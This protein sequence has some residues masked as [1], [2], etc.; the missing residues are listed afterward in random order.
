[1]TP[2]KRILHL[3]RKQLAWLGGSLLLA[4]AL[5]AGSHF[6]RLEMGQRVVL[7]QGRLAAQQAR[8]EETRRDLQ[9]IQS[10]IQEYRALK[11]KGLV[12]QPDREGWVEALTSSRSALKA[13]E[14]LS[15]VLGSP[16]PRDAGSPNQGEFAG[17][18]ERFHDLEFEL[19]N[20]HEEELLGL[21]RHYRETVHGRFRIEL[22][23]LATPTSAG[24][25]A[26]CIL[27]FVTLTEKEKPAQ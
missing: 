10:H 22:C 17:G 25:F 20:V 3:A 4:L 8:L 19:R 11:E 12:G 18:E 24:L 7:T 5:I 14:G 2:Q 9:N 21:L 6:Y 16:I 13:G 27:R 26:K 1:M 23:V 15:Y